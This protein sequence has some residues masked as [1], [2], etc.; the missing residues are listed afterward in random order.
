MIIKRYIWD[1]ISCFDIRMYERNRMAQYRHVTE[2][3]GACYWICRQMLWKCKIIQISDKCKIHAYQY[4]IF[5]RIHP[6]LD[7]SFPFPIT[8]PISISQN[9][10]GRPLGHDSIVDR[11]QSQR[12]LH[13]LTWTLDPINLLILSRNSS[14]CNRL[15]FSFKMWLIQ[16]GCLYTSIRKDQVIT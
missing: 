7:R 13:I 16:D 3:A 10:F 6:I 5:S 8:F 12:C 11:E 14:K 9:I 4:L 15:I 2:Y 1:E